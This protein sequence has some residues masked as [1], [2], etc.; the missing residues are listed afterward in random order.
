[1]PPICAIIAF[2][3][4]IQPL[5]E[6]TRRLVRFQRRFRSDSIP[7]RILRTRGAP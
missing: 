2:T 7:V 4:G 1:M 5:L 6:V 3:G